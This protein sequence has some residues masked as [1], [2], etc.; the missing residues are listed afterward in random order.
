MK[1]KSFSCARL[2]VTPWTAAHQALPSMGF[3]RQ[4]YWSV[5]PLPSPNDLQAVRKLLSS[6]LFLGLS[7]EVPPATAPNVMQHGHALA[8]GQ[9]AVSSFVCSVLCRPAVTCHKQ[10]SSCL[11]YLLLLLN[12]FLYTILLHLILCIESAQ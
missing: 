3:S 9:G 2:L 6:S 1:V 10:I 7:D 11:F 12:M 8:L 4:E 5:L